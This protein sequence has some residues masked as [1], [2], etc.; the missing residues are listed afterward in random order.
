MP[1]F[2]VLYFG[3]ILPLQ[4]VPVIL[5]AIGLLRQDYDYVSVLATDSRGLSV[6]ISQRARAVGS[7]TMTTERGIV[8]R[9]CRDGLY[10]EYALNTFDPAK[11]AEAAEEIRGA[12]ARQHSSRRVRSWICGRAGIASMEKKREGKRM[13]WQF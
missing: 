4:G 11:P 9:V 6:S 8:V 1:D 12:F 7:E 2:T 5:D 3:S 13:G 10:S